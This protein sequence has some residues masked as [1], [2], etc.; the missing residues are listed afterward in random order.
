MTHYKTPKTV[1]NMYS[2]RVDENVYLWHIMLE[3]GHESLIGK[4]S[5]RNKTDMIR[6]RCYA[7]VI[8]KEEGA[9]TL[10][11]RIRTCM[12]TPMSEFSVDGPKDKWTFQLIEE[13]L[14]VAN[15]VEQ[16]ETTN[17]ELLEALE[18]AKDDLLTWIDETHAEY[19]CECVTCQETLPAITEAIK[20]A[21]S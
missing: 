18:L 3:C 2:K 17:A 6:R 5:D 20:K 15:E 19:P 14:W 11:K 16:L 9:I 13:Q 8:A 21:K 4:F 12:T 1:G 10:S 7:C